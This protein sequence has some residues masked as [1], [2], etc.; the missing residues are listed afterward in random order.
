[1]SDTP[2]SQ[3]SAARIGGL[4]LVIGGG[5][6]LVLCVGV[7]GFV[8][9]YTT[10]TAF[11]ACIAVVIG[12]FCV[13][14]PRRIP[15][16]FVCGLGPLG[17]VLIAMSSILTRTTTDGSELLYLWPVLFSAYFLSWRN[18]LFNVVLIAVSYPPIAISILG[19]AGIT[20][21]VYM[22]GTAVVTLVVTASLR[23]QVNRLVSSIALEAR[24][25]KLT[26]LPNRR[27]WDDRFAD[28]VSRAAPMCLLMIDLDFFKRLNDT[29]GHAAGDSALAFVAG[30]L[31]A[32]TRPTDVLARIGGE[33]FGAALRDCALA[34][35]LRRAE[36][37][38]SAVE[39]ES[40]LTV[41][42]G[43]A[44]LHIDATTDRALM[45]AA[46]GALY[47]A[48]RSGRNAVRAVSVDT[49]TS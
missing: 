23:R 8:H 41:S 46:D 14:N 22:V 16:W 37:I 40:T 38:R 5:L 47:S 21:S 9:G 18:A 17:T 27:S 44:A 43:V 24:T 49:P 2:Y 35:G 33:E 31:R 13:L 45:A 25:D 28:H 30:V 48:K 7:P 36:Q 19:V 10:P 32:Q 34:D 11:V 39:S 4:L 3:T 6:A 29:Q 1:M 15:H 26:D 42:V 12:L 20:P